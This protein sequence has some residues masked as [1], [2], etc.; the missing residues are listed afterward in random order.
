MAFID[1]CRVHDPYIN[2][3]RRRCDRELQSRDISPVGKSRAGELAD[4]ARRLTDEFA[5][6]S[7]R[8]IANVNGTE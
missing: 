6:I 3:G 2:R 5:M 7:P 1:R 4:D 8:L